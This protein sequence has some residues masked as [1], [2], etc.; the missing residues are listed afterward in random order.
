MFY[1][2]KYSKMYSKRNYSEKIGLLKKVGKIFC[3]KN[4]V[5]FFVDRKRF[6]LPPTLWRKV[7]WI[8]HIEG[9]KNTQAYEQTNA[10]LCTIASSP[11]WFQTCAWEH[12]SFTLETRTS[13]KVAELK[14]VNPGRRSPNLSHS[15]RWR[16]VK[17]YEGGILGGW[18][19]EGMR[20]FW[21][22]ILCFFVEGGFS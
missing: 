20:I 19:I 9:K 3:S 11:S 4:Y 5:T 17:T 10:E 21:Y 12:S 18:R 16:G 6:V 13:R 1:S 7:P 22:C 15:T 14:F 2:K 8:H